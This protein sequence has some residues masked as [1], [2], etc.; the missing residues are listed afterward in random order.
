MNLEYKGYSLKLE[1][2]VNT[3]LI[4]TEIVKGKTLYQKLFEYLIDGKIVSAKGF[5]RVIKRHDPTNPVSFTSIMNSMSRIEAAL[6]KSHNPGLK[7][8]VFLKQGQGG[9]NPVINREN[10]KSRLTPAQLRILDNATEE[11]MSQGGCYMS[12]LREYC[13]AALTNKNLGENVVLTFGTLKRSLQRVRIQRK[14]LQKPPLADLIVMN[15][16]ERRTVR[17]RSK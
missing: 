15:P 9:Y 4:E 7:K 12:N 6:K 16:S 11:K 10:S 14:K 3:Y 17:K 1:F 8:M 5:A 2:L 13:L